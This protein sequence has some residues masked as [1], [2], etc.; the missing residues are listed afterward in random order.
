MTTDRKRRCFVISPIGPEGSAVREHA[1]EVFDFIVQPALDACGIEAFR[2]DHLREPGKIS[3]QMF[4]AILNDDLCVAVLTGFNPNVF[5]EL[6]VAQAA[7]RPVVILLEKSQ[8]LPFD[9]QDLRCVAYD[10][11]LRSYAERTYINEVIGHVRSLEAA[12]WR[13]PPPFGVQPPLGGRPDGQQ[14]V[15]WP[16]ALDQRGAGTWLQLVQGAAERIDVMGISLG[17]LRSG[18]GVSEM[19][20]ARAKAGCRVRVLFMHKDHPALRELVRD[21]ELERRYE[22]KVRDIDNT[23]AHFA[24][25]RQQSPNIAVRQ[26]RH[27]C[28]FVTATRTEERAVFVQHFYSE[29]LRYCPLWECARGSRLHDLLGQEFEAL[30]QA[31]ADG[32]AAPAGPKKQ[33]GRRRDGLR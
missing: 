2:S 30:W 13:V 4:K 16:Q 29:K 19:L 8:A 10:L 25:L 17:F 28:P 21:T 11:R 33:P 6:A 22:P 15:F 32:A 7:A 31:N 5:Y 14:P 20:A 3:E 12:G 18:K 24:Q 9:L 1:D 27:G 23:E 26:M